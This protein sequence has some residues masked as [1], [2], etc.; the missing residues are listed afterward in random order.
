MLSAAPV[1][2]ITNVHR[3]RSWAVL[4]VLVVLVLGAPL[5]LGH[6]TNTFSLGSLMLGPRL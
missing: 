2:D 3:S 5:V 1:A 6:E 4:G